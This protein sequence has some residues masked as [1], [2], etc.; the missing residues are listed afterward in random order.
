V[1]CS[2][3]VDDGV[4]DKELGSAFWELRPSCGRHARCALM[5]TSASPERA[6]FV[7]SNR[8]L[9][10]KGLGADVDHRATRGGRPA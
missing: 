5:L 6:Q 7:A 10:R 1:C 9:R 4:T 2:G 8:Y 3:L